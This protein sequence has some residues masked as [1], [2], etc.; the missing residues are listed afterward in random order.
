MALK[1]REEVVGKRFLALKKTGAESEKHNPSAVRGSG[2]LNSQNW[3]SGNIRAASEKN[4]GHQDTQ[5]SLSQ[6]MLCKIN[7]IIGD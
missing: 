5:V 3:I 1:Y 2:Y 4:V 7:I 6:L